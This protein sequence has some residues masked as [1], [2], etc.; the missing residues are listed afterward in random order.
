MNE[1]DFSL[2]LTDPTHLYSAPAVNPMSPA[3]VEVLGVS[4]FDFLLARLTSDRSLQAS[5]HLVI[6]LPAE[7]SAEQLKTAIQHIAGARIE[8]ER[9]ELRGTYRSGWRV[10]GIA[11]LILAVCIAISHLF[12]SDL[13]EGMRPLIRKTFEY[14]FEIIGWVVMWN[15][16]D[17]LVFT[18]LTIRQ[19]IRALQALAGMDVIVRVDERAA[20][21]VSSPAV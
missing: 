21:P 17:F 7:A 15:P 3:T 2:T 12:G 5:R 1:S 6:V 19:R 14:G 8:R 18:P 10:L 4:G 11:L 16:I 20:L 9:Q 13:T